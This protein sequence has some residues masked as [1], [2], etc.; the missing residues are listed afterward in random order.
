MATAKDLFVLVWIHGFL[1]GPEVKKH[2]ALNAVLCTR[3]YPP[4]E[5]IHSSC[6]QLQWIKIWQEHANGGHTEPPLFRAALT[7][8]TFLPSQYPG[9][10]L[11]PTTIYNQVVNLTG[12]SNSTDSFS[13]LV[14]V[15]AETPGSANNELVLDGFFG[16]FTFVPVVDGKFIIER[17]ILT[18]KNESVNGE[19]LLSMTNAFKGRAFVQDTV[20][21]ASDYARELFPLLD[22]AQISAVATEYAAFHGTLPT[23]YDQAIGIMGESI[24]ICPTYYLLQAFKGRSWKGEFAILPANHGDDLFYYF[25]SYGTPWNNTEFIA[26]LSGSFLDVVASLNP[27]DKVNTEDTT[28]MWNLWSDGYTEMIFNRTANDEPDIRPTATDF[29]LLKRCAVAACSR[30]PIIS[31]PPTWK[32]SQYRIPI[33]IVPRAIIKTSYLADE[34]DNSLA[35]VNAAMPDPL[36]FPSPPPSN[37]SNTLS[38]LD[39]LPTPTASL[40]ADPPP[41]YPSPRRN[42]GARRARG[43]VQPTSHS[44]DSEADAHP[45]SPTSDREDAIGETTPLINSGGGRLRRSSLSHTSIL[46][47]A[48]SAA[49]SLAHTVVSLFH[50]DADDEDEGSPSPAGSGNEDDDHTLPALHLHSS[51]ARRAHAQV[52]TTS[53]HE[54]SER[55]RMRGTWR[56]YFRPMVRKVYWGALFHLLVLNFPFALVA[57]IYLFVFTL[58]GTTLMILL[59][60][61]ALLCFFDLLGARTFARGELALQTR[62]H[63]PPP[64]CPLPHPPRPIFTRLAA[65]TSSDAEAGTLSAYEGSFYKNTYAMFTD[66]TSYQALFYFLVIK[67]PIVILLS[68]VLLVL[69]PVCIVLVV[70]APAF[71]RAVRKIGGWQAGVAIEGLW[72]AVR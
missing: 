22:H 67:P 12:C 53:S 30:Y 9:D 50:P 27:N 48:S 11:I 33:V 59:P 65:P 43:R 15:D 56:R 1:A 23:V 62:F 34:K 31:S 7:S 10:G 49:P 3:S 25:T 70:P 8:S 32:Q 47:Y 16:T 52:Q 66:P 57:W 68:L 4:V 38:P 46:S 61:G 28:P 14:T 58:T 2:G 54:S 13:C 18:L 41:P 24:F 21:N 37:I 44:T 51:R 60:L 42:R 55:E 17:P 36:L 71:L 39:V 29:G 20:T 72:C 35:L 19:V 69:A 63:R 26:S 6:L 64:S 40:A 5:H 45:R